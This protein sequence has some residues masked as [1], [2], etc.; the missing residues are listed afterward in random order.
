MRELEDLLYR[1]IID[2]AAVA[3]LL[4][5]VY[6]PIHTKKEHIFTFVV[7]NIII[8]LI[9]YLLNSV[10]LS[11]GA[12]FGLF[13]VFSMLRYRTEDI[14]IKDMTYLFLMISIGLV[15]A[16]AKLTGKMDELDLAYLAGINVLLILVV[17]IL[18]KSTNARFERIKLITF[19]KL[20]LIH[21]SKKTE[22]IAD[23]RER[24]G[25]DVVEVEIVKIDFVRNSAS[26][27]VHYTKEKEQ[28]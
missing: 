4:R 19:D 10:E 26:L 28:P 12:A 25:L 9:C 8:F 1:F 18:E 2:I 22:L 5:K 24:T 20:D 14:G 21:Q 27:K 23:L 13:A 11:M 7:L 3:V 17:W 15:T 6:L 16:I